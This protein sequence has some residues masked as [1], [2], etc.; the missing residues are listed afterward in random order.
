LI[1]NIDYNEL[2]SLIRTHTSPPPDSA[3]PVVIPGQED[4]ELERFEA[5]FARELGAQHARIDL[6]VR[7][8]ADEFQRRLSEFFFLSIL[9]VTL[10]IGGGGRV[11]REQQ[12]KES[13]RRDGIGY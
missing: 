9:G 5:R 11:E 2:K 10:W 8:K 3:K 6:F 1:D 7:S 13:G 12:V 4:K